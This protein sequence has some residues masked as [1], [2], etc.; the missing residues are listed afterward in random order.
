MNKLIDINSNENTDMIKFLYNYR[1]L[2]GSICFA[3]SYYFCIL[4]RD[5]KITL[6]ESITPNIPTYSET[7]PSLNSLP[8][9]EQTSTPLTDSS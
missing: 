6:T 9:Y 5:N 3:L 7:T 2:I 1:V 4:Y 8:S